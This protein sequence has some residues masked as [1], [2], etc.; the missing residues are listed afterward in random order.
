[1]ISA[2]SPGIKLIASDV[3][4]TDP[5]GAEPS[6]FGFAAAIAKPFSAGELSFILNEVLNQ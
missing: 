6:A 4:E 1:M 3:L 5:I 2:A